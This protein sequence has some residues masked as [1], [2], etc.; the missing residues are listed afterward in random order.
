MK[1]LSVKEKHI[2]V[3][4]GL[5]RQGASKKDFQYPEAIDI[6][7]IKAESRIIKDRLFPDPNIPFKFEINE[8]YVSD[9]QSIIKRNYELVTFQQSNQ[10]SYGVLPYDFGYLISDHSNIIE[11]CK[12]EFTTPTPTETKTERVIVIP[13]TSA[14]GSAPYYQNI[15]VKVLATSNTLTFT[16]YQTLEERTF[17]VDNIINTFKDLGLI[18]YWESY[19][20]IYRSNSFL[21]PI[22]DLSINATINIDGG[23]DVIV[24]NIDKTVTTFKSTLTTNNIILNRDVKADFL[25]SASASFYNRSN[26]DSPLSSLY[27]NKILVKG[28]E[29]FLANKIFINY[30]RTPRRI[31]LNLNQNSEL[32]GTVHE[33]ICD[34]AIQLLKKQIEDESYEKEVQDNKNR[35]ET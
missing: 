27:E 20:D 33:E 11:D 22:L 28:T 17:I 35:I 21:L 19:K 23:T 18:A 5:Q 31:S 32:S 9:I 7:L 13:F 12:D 1:R 26:P 15:I 6:A 30:I 29:R 2:Y 24:S 10:E 25:D 34:L 14:K 8:K 4:Q 3:T 16:G